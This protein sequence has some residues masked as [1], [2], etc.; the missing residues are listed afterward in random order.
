MPKY[1]C[2]W[3]LLWTIGAQA[4][5]YY[6]DSA[7][8]DDQRAGTSPEASWKSLA[9]INGTIFLPGDALLLKSGSAWTGQLWPKGSGTEKQVITLGKYGT[10]PNPLVEGQGQVED[11][12]LLKN[13][14]YWEV[15]D[16]ELSNHADKP[17]VRRGVH[18]TGENFGELHHI[19][20]RSL[21]VH[22]VSGADD[23]KEN[24][25]II[26]TSN[27]KAKPTRFV[28]LRIEN[29]HVF[30]T[31]RN[32]ISGWSTHWARSSWYPSLGV[33][34]RGNHLEDI[35]GDGIMIAVT[36]GALIEHNVV[37]HANQRSEG[38]NIAIWSWSADNTTIQFNE[39]YGTRSEHDGEGFDSD[40]NSRNTLIQYNYSHDNE[41]GFLLICN[42]GETG[43][44]SIGNVGTIARYNI[45]Q[46]DHNRGINLAGPVKDTQIYNNTIYVGK[47]HKTDVLVYS[48]WFGWADNTSIFN[49]IFYVEGEGQIAYGTVRDKMTGHHSTA[50]GLGKSIGNRFDSNIYFGLPAVDDQHGL[51]S[52]P[53][54]ALPGDGPQGYVLRA[55][56]PAIDSAKPLEKQRDYFGTPIPACGGVDRG[57]VETST[58]A[59]AKH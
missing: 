6:V 7:T 8:G 45:S 28:D 35:G 46:N 58:C 4:K 52:D 31:D 47:S 10:G 37:A 14:E 20:L 44:E 54:F 30:H 56:S 32:G 49:N 15:S 11:A 5:T 39:A 51:T 2:L 23:S 55:N 27:G 48:D 26:Y 24:G 40:W 36:D 16:L 19:Y 21:I 38:Y 57:A 22:D 43:P 59:P 29:N 13:Q 3:L 1:I 25:G 34:V 17:A 41:G 12:F 53:L 18:V 9:K 42:S 33:V 50:P